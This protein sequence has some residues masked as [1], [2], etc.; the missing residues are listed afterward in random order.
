MIK[1][2][3]I[4]GLNLLRRIYSALPETNDGQ[5]D[6]EQFIAASGN[7]FQ[8]IL[9]QHQPSHAVCVLEHYQQT[10]R[11]QLFPPYKENRKPQPAAMLAAFERLQRLAE[12]SGIHWLDVEGYEADDIIASIVHTTRNFD[13]R[14]L[15]LSTD[16]L[17]AQL[18]DKHTSLYDHF[19]QRPIDR[20][21]IQKRYGVAPAQL[22]D[23]FALVGSSSVNIHGI[24]GIGAKTAANLLEQYSD[25]KALLTADDL[26]KKTA[27][28]LENAEAALYLYRGL[29]Q[30]RE[31]CPI[32]GNLKQWRVTSKGI[33]TL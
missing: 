9:S 4:D 5:P 30:L 2:L 16:H 33:R 26:D 22:P 7:A 25:C 31:D 32:H 10:W 18:L 11:H 14:N 24:S 28:R 27:T 19:G 29:F 1:L 15:I 23:Y 17:M 12:Q 21:A 3:I 13:C 6:I 8:H 20:D